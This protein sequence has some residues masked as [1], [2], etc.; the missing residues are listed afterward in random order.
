MNAIQKLGW[1]ARLYVLI[2]KQYIKARMEY[3]TDFIISS[4]G[5][6]FSNAASLAMF[7]ALFHSIPALAGWNFYEIIFIYGFYLLAVSPAQIFFDNI[8]QLRWLV[9]DGKFIK[10][11]FR[12]LNMMFYFMSEVFD[13]KGL[14]QV[15]V[16]IA[17][18]VWVSI[19][20][21]LVWTL[22]KVL[23]LLL[24][25]F[26]ASMVVISILT[27]AACTCFWVLYSFSILNLAFR[28]REYSQYPMTIF[29]GFFRFIF[30]YIIPI[31]FVAFYP[32][33]LF[34]RPGEN[35][36]LIILSPIVGIG[37]FA[38]TYGIWTL[39]VNSYSGTGS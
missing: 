17:A 37:L 27:M 38:L 31:G 29:D 4:V 1:Y 32:S 20:L 30:T 3:R 7:W 19:K 2:E 22:P 9:V 33:Q 13:L 10:Y 39:G 21:G 16:G 14:S 24:A 34:L 26:S 6:I 15:V 11:Y 12:P 36:W 28:L 23:L 35:T 18:L 25:L 8:W 5:M